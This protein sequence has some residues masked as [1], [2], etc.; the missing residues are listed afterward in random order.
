[1]IRLDKQEVNKDKLTLLSL[2]LDI[3]E[4]SGFADETK[5]EILK[6]SKSLL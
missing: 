2:K 1:M 5:S 3:A 6:Q 4:N